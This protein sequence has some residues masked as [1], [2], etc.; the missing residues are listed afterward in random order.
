MQVFRVREFKF[1]PF[2]TDDKT[3]ATG[4]VGLQDNWQEFNTSVWNCDGEVVSEPS[5]SAR[6]SEFY[7]LIKIHP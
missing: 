2:V 5:I 6:Y 4:C 1:N 3:P 7:Y